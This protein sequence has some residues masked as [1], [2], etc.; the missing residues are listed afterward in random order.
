MCG[1]VFY[2]CL[3][4]ESEKKEKKKGNQ[5]RGDAL[6]IYVKACEKKNSAVNAS[7][8]RS[9]NGIDY[10]Y[11]YHY[12]VSI[13]IELGNGLLLFIPGLCAFSEKNIENLINN[14]FKTF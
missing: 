4:H 1:G 11:Y 12:L 5:G 13:R 10:Y 6:S 14:N 9:S 2:S 3:S 8:P 7:P